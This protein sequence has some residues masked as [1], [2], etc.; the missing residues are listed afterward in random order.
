MSVREVFD[1]ASHSDMSAPFF[2]TP[3]KAGIPEELECC[4]F[5][6]LDLND[7]VIRHPGETC[8]VQADGHSMEPEIFAGDILAVDRAIEAREGDVVIAMIEGEM[9]IKRLEL[10][11][12]LRLV[13][14][15]QYYAPIS[16]DPN[17]DF[18]VWGVVTYRI[19]LMC[20]RYEINLKQ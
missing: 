20:R 5:T 9:V 11:P 7:F 4:A 8:Y 15:N 14:A 6:E 13:S 18:M 17:T 3:I 12:K 16:V 2:S 1:P 19:S 10:Y